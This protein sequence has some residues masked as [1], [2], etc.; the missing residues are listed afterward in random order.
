MATRVDPTFCDAHAARAMIL[1]GGGRRADAMRALDT[2]LN[3]NSECTLGRLVRGH[4]LM[5]AD[6][7]KAR[8]DLEKVIELNGD[9]PAGR[10][11][12]RL[13]EEGRK[14]WSLADMLSVL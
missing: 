5:R 1:A 10:L 2:A 12:R 6:S 3:H 14:P 13:L 11:A 4:L 8:E 7:E 9:G